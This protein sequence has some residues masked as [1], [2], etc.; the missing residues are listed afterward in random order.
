MVGMRTF[1]AAVAVVLAG[2]GIEAVTA[3]DAN[4]TA[5]TV[6][7]TATTVDCTGGLPTVDYHIV[8][9]GFGANESLTIGFVNR[10]R[11]DMPVTSSASGGI[12]VV[13]ELPGASAPQLQITDNGSQT[14]VYPPT[15][16]SAPPCTPGIFVPLTP[17]RILDTRTT[18]G[19]APGPIASGQKVAL[20][21]TGAGGVPAAGVGAV[22]LTITATAPAGAGVVTAFPDGQSLP[23]ASNLNYAKGQT[24]PNL[25]V[26]PVGANGKVDLQVTGGAAQ[27][28]ADVSGYFVAGT[29]TAPGTFG[30]LTPARIL[31]SRSGVGVTAGAIA[32]GGTVALKVTGQGNVPT[33]GVGAVV[34]N[35]TATGPT[36]PGLV[37]AYPAGVSAPNAS[38][39]NYSQGQTVAN[40]VVVPV[41]ANGVVNLHVSGSGTVQ[42][43]ADVA[44]YFLSGSA[45]TAGAFGPLT[46]ARLLDT[47]SG[48][49]APAGAVAGGHTVALQVEGRGGVPA[50]G[51]SAV[52]LNVTVTSPTAT[53]FITV[54]ADGTAL[55]T[56]SNVNYVAGQTVANLVVAPL[57]STGKV[58]LRVA[59]GGT[60]QLIADV[61]GYIVA[62]AGSLSGTVTAANGGAPLGNVQVFA[63]QVGTSGSTPT[64]SGVTAADGTY[65]VRRLAPAANGYIVCFGAS[66]AVGPATPLGYADRCYNGFQWN[67]ALGVSPFGNAVFAGT[68]TTVLNTSLPVNGVLSGTVTTAD[69]HA[70]AAN[71]PVS[72]WDTNGRVI[73]RAT[74]DSNGTWQAFPVSPGNVLVCFDASTVLTSQFGYQSQCY[75]AQPWDGSS[76]PVATSITLNPGTVVNTINASLAPFPAVTGK[77]TN[78]ATHDGLFNVTVKLFNSSG[79]VVKTTTT[80]ADGTYAL[81]KVTPGAYFVCFDGSTAAPPASDQCYNGVAWDG[82]SKPSSTN[83]DTLF[84]VTS[85]KTGVNAVLVPQI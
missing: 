1:T 79:A 77:V 12:D 76:R 21:V 39:L 18:L 2:V 8:G 44:G 61:S 55:P 80:M 4:A 23:T 63:Y 17:A 53:G 29:P 15:A 72:V 19:G 16:V 11:F 50:A 45:T 58:D 20:Q 57:S 48:N 73:A 64:S 30:P 69:T 75:N 65:S 22:A 82:T 37:T 66:N 5:P 78:S 9:S 13:D 38:N 6:T 36:A 74:T 34:L 83:H 46:P 10:P 26:V 43:I 41:G 32:A 40:L 31:D 14:V 70:P 62:N 52:L 28:L 51:V 24:V 7:V 42:L 81:T 68:G 71:V 59:G 27:L 84:G 47:R 49:G 35:L 25:A 56:A 3:A 60:V 85:V 54:Y 67:Q 33:S